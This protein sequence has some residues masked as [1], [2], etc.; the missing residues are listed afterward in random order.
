MRCLLTQAVIV[1]V[2][3]MFWGLMSSFSILSWLKAFLALRYGEYPNNT[4]IDVPGVLAK[5]GL[6]FRSAHSSDLLHLLDAL[7]VQ[8]E[9]LP[10]AT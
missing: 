5:S 8:Q 9:M 10:C 4:V 2:N 7:I 1:L 3:N 6:I